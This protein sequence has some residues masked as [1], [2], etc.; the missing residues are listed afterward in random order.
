L[1]SAALPTAGKGLKRVSWALHD[2]R[3]SPPALERWR[4]RAPGRAEERD[5]F[6]NLVT[7]HLV[8]F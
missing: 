3:R 2:E 7:P 1:L 8:P 4:M 5:R 6:E